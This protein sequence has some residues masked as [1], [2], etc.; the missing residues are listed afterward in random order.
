MGRKCCLVMGVFVLVFLLNAP[1]IG[2]TYILDWKWFQILKE[3][4]LIFFPP[5]MGGAGEGFLVGWM[6]SKFEMGHRRIHQTMGSCGEFVERKMIWDGETENFLSNFWN[7]LE[8]CWRNVYFKMGK[9]KRSWQIFIKQENLVNEKTLIVF[10]FH[11]FYIC[12]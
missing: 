7:F 8:I 2:C 10:Y 6:K 12:R 9:P 4:K 1:A 5:K 11:I 3:G